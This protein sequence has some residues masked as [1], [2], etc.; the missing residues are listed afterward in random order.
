VAETGGWPKVGYQRYDPYCC[1]CLNVLGSMRL[2]KAIIY[3][4]WLVD[5]YLWVES[6]GSFAG[7]SW[8]W[9]W[10]RYQPVCVTNSI[11]PGSWLTSEVVTVPYLVAAIDELKVKYRKDQA[12]KKFMLRALWDFQ[13]GQSLQGRTNSG[14]F[15]LFGRPGSDAATSQNRGSCTQTMRPSMFRNLEVGRVCAWWCKLGLYWNVC[16]SWSS[17]FVVSGF[18]AL[19]VENRGCEV[20][21]QA[22]FPFGESTVNIKHLDCI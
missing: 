9:S 2:R 1:W 7:W 16:W 20:R 3:V 17:S 14:E 5:E 10:G 4:D 18:M 15:S 13:G 21:H 19:L 22:S 8:L 12:T 11:R 6:L